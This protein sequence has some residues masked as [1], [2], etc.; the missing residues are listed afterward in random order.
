MIQSLLLFYQK[1]KRDLEKVGFK[2]NPY[3]P[4]VANKMVNGLSPD[5][6]KYGKDKEQQKKL[7]LTKALAAIC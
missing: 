4:C 3:S 6:I 7:K 2:V 1:L 5:S